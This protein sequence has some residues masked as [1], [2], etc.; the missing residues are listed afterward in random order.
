MNI[1]VQQNEMSL[2][3]LLTVDCTAPENSTEE[4]TNPISPVSSQEQTENKPLDNSVR[5]Y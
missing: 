1:L 4:S 5:I 3:D 2:D